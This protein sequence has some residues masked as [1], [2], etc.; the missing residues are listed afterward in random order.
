M[1]GQVKQ[2]VL[3]D[4]LIGSSRTRGDMCQDHRKTYIG[5]ATHK[6][7]DGLDLRNT[8]VRFL[9]LGLE[10]LLAFRWDFGGRT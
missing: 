1:V 7:F 3:K 8:N 9:C 2:K 10:T 6:K 5:Y 4:L